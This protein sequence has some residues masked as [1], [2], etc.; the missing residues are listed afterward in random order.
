MWGC[1]CSLRKLSGMVRRTVVR[2]SD[3][4][5]LWGSLRLAP[6]NPTLENDTLH[7]SMRVARLELVQEKLVQEELA[8]CSIPFQQPQNTAYVSKQEQYHYFGIKKLTSCCREERDV[9]QP[10]TSPLALPIVLVLKKDRSCVDYRKL[11]TITRKDAYP[12]PR[13]NPLT[14][15]VAIW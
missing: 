3:Y 7:K 8:D 5:H 9:I 6:I 15:T 4:C 2:T 12:L 14:A 13:I 10:S 11:N 1:P